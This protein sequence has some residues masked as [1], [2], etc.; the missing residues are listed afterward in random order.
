MKYSGHRKLICEL[1]KLSNLMLLSSSDT[2]RTLMHLFLF[3]NS[4][5]KNWFQYVRRVYTTA[6]RFPWTSVLI[7]ECSALMLIKWLKRKRWRFLNSTSTRLTW[8]EKSGSIWH[9]CL[10]STSNSFHLQVK[11]SGYSAEVKVYSKQVKATFSSLS[12]IFFATRSCMVDISQYFFYDLRVTF[13]NIHS[14]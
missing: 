12:L 7:Q 13:E 4:P 8:I 5:R 9:L 3:T 14:F 6:I 10:L 1:S 2:K 11:H